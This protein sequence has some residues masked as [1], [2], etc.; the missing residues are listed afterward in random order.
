MADEFDPV[1]DQEV[2]VT[3]GEDQDLE[4]ETDD[5]GQDEDQVEKPK[6]PNIVKQ[7]RE[8]IKKLK[9][10]L[11]DQNKSEVKLKPDQEI[12]SR[13]FFV[14]NPEAKDYKDDIRVTIAKFPAMSFDEAYAYV[15]ALKPK[16]ST[17][18]QDFNF[19][20]KSKPADMMRLTDDEAA[21]QLSPADYLKYTRSNGSNFLKSSFA[22]K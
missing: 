15:K 14:E 16:E 12:D 9:Q 13:F 11:K 20:T 18:K 4:S 5:E 1:E 19:R 8:E 2:D 21:E 7:Q 10:A 17:T 3:E 22:R 6:K